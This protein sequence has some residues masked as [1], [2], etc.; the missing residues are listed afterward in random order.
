MK[1]TRK[2]N[3]IDFGDMLFI[4]Y[5]ILKNKKNILKKIQQRYEYILVD[6]FQDTNYIQLQIVHLLS[7]EHKRICVV[8][9]DDQSIYRFRGA[10]TSN[11][12]EFKRLFPTFVEI[13]LEE[14]YRSTKNIVNVAEKLILNN[15][16]Q[17][18]S[19]T[20]FTNNEEGDYV[21][22]IECN[23]E[24]TQTHYIINKVLEL[25]KTVDSPYKLKDIAILCRSRSS[26][27][28]LINDLKR[29]QIPFQFIGYSDFFTNAVIKDIISL[30]KIIDNPVLANGE[31]VRTLER[32]CYGLKRTEVAKLSNLA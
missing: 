23:N 4:V 14:N 21:S 24:I 25:T 32:S 1:I 18:S 10:Y 30:L 27:I 20:I 11:I 28:P 16:P 15:N 19:K 3:I 8:G 26:A 13:A 5:R 29:R 9:D 7:K 17:R 12:G 2:N 6:E 31:L 22:V